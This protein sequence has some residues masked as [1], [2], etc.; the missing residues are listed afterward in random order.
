MSKFVDYKIVQAE[1]KGDLAKTIKEMF[2][3][4]WYFQAMIKKG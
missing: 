3:D 4:G 2:K 1:F